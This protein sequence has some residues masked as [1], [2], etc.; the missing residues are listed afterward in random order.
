MMSDQLH[1]EASIPIAA[2]VRAFAHRLPTPSA[3]RLFRFRH[4]N[5]DMPVRDGHRVDRSLCE[6]KSLESLDLELILRTHSANCHRGSAKFLHS[7]QPQDRD[8]F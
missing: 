2:V 7:D 6:P 5:P 4:S 3:A 8:A 1:L